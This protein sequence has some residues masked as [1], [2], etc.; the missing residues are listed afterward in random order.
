MA[1]GTH[2]PPTPADLIVSMTHLMGGDLNGG[3]NA[4]LV[5]GV[6]NLLNT[7]YPDAAYV[8][9]VQERC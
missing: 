1:K 5:A 6:A 8:V 2:F 9:R 7:V 3:N 4:T